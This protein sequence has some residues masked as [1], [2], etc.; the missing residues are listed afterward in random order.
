LG[1]FDLG[2]VAPGQTLELVFSRNTGP[3]NTESDASIFWEKVDG[4][5]FTSSLN[6]MDID[7]TYKIPA[8]TRGNYALELTLEGSEVGT[9]APHKMTLKMYVTEDVYSFGYEPSLV[10]SA[11]TTEDVVVKITSMSAAS[12]VINFRSTE[13]IP[14]GW[15]NQNDVVIGPGETKMVTMKVTPN[16]EGMYNAKIKAGRSSSAIQD[17]LPLNVRVKPTLSSKLK[18]FGEGFSII[19]VIMQPF[20]S[21]LSLLGAIA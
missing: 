2:N 20:Y 11:G 3:G 19:P 17:V 21:L 14:S 6:G 10:M 18:A 4:I 5:G 15:I 16:E 9:I 13:G 8:A 7:V 1:E 12:D